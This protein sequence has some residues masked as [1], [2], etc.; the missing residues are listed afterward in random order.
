MRIPLE[1]TN[2][3]LIRLRETKTSEE[4]TELQKSTTDVM[5]ALWELLCSRME[6]CMVT[7]HEVFTCPLDGKTYVVEMRYYEQDKLNEK[8]K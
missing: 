1:K 2:V 3:P 8:P 5:L 4:L 6:D 7:N